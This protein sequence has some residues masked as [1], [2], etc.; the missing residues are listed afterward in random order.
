MTYEWYSKT[1]GGTLSEAAFASTL[2]AADRHVGWLV[3]MRTPASG[4]YRAYRRALCAACECFA[5]Y[6][7]GQVGGFAIG[8]FRVTHYED[9]GTTGAEL[10]T[11]AALQELAGTSLLF[12]GVC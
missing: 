12:S 6:G 5:E 2:P 7:E 1:Y 11:Q 10:A 8:D 9:E 3:G 4:E